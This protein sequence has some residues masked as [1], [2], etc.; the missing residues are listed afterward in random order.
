MKLKDSSNCVTHTVMDLTQ[1][2]TQIPDRRPG[3]LW[4]KLNRQQVRPNIAK[5]NL[6][7]STSLKYK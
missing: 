3:T 7:F 1:A 4:S 6:P 2:L 5:N